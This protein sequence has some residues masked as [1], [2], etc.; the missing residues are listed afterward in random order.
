MNLLNKPILN[1]MV[2][3]RTCLF[4]AALVFV[5][6]LSPSVEAAMWGYMTNPNGIYRINTQTGAATLL[7]GGAPFDGATIVA[8]VG[9]RPSD[10]MVFFTFNNITN[11]QVYRWDPATPATAPVLLGTTGAA[12]PY[13]HRLAF[14]PTSGVLY[15]FDINGTVLWTINQATGAAT[16]VA[17]I[18]GFP[19]A[20]SGDVAFQ[21]GTNNLYAATYTG[22]ALNVYLIP[23]AGGAVTLTGVVTGL[24][25]GGNTV[26]STMFNSAGTMF[27]G[28]SVADSGGNYNLYTAPVTGGAATL[29]G[30]M[31]VLAQDYGSVPAPPP[32]ITK[33]FNPTAVITNSNSVLTLTLT[34]TYGQGQ[35]GAAV[36]DTYPAGVVNAPVPAGATTCGGAVTAVAG[37]NTV[38]LSGGTIPAGG[39][40]TVTVNVRSAAVGV[41]NNSIAIGGLSTV[42]GFNDAAGNATLTVA[43]PNLTMVKASTAYSDPFN[44]TTNPKRIPASFVN[45]SIV[46]SNTGAGP[47]DSNAV[48]ITDAIP[49]NTELFV[50]D[51]GGA[52]SGPVAFADG[53]P[54]SGLTYTFTALGNG[55]DDVSFSNNGGATYVYTPVPNGNGVD[56]TVTN[57]QI[58]PKGIFTGNSSFTLTFR[59]RVK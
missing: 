38:S 41:Y 33:S 17:A 39:S 27:L 47:V 51:L 20:V 53:A 1:R 13:L 54:S 36:T 30:S 25:A 24:P 50:N 21:P 49:A 14:H 2:T 34:N 35:R 26:T 11:Q 42:L 28:G 43:L 10:G 5:L 12:V 23:L 29:I 56:T 45:Y 57:I 40:C 48:V 19:G 55:A 46:V 31:G 44:G 9:E 18:A 59:V 3:K 6:L 32:T 15:A 22:G 52:G 58:N 8:G 4:L 16:N 37:A 7:Y